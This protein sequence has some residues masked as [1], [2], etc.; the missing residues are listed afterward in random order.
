MDVLSLVVCP[1]CHSRVERGE[2]GFRC[3]NEECALR[4]QGFPS[5]AGQPALVDFD[6]S[7]FNREQL[8]AQAGA[9]EDRRVEAP[10][11]PANRLKAFLF[12]TNNAAREAANLF[13]RRL[14]GIP[15]AKVLVVG[16]GTI[17]SGMEGLY[18]NPDL[19]IVGTD[20]YASP[21]TAL[22]A[23]AHQL[24]FP[25]RSFDAV[26]VQAVLE[27]VLDP[28]GVVAEIHRVL[29]PRGLVYADTPF[30][31]QVHEEAYDFSRFTLSGHRW[32]FQNFELISTGPVKGVGTS[33]NWSI[34]YFTRALTRS[35]R[36]AT[37]VGLAFF[38]LRFFDD[39]GD[40]GMNADGASGI[41]FIGSKSSRPMP[42]R[43]MVA[44]YRDRQA[45]HRLGRRPPS[46]QPGRVPGV[47]A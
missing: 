37:L 24:P 31:Q 7:I 46:P 45:Y 25:D 5:V 42:P 18:A 28:A 8:R 38:W 3:T 17:G 43:D 36:L 29:K 32:L 14:R 41:Y 27:H 19:D 47:E 22:I 11:S 26:W 39:I 6:R 21:N 16:G 20:V 13:A 15:G 35:E 10:E 1:R 40:F 12:G 30:M 44:F 34:R 33:L 2:G 9:L 4:E 23:D